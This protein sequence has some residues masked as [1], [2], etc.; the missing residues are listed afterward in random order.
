M[1]ALGRRM[2]CSSPSRHPSPATHRTTRAV[3]RTGR[4]LCWSLA[5]GMTTAA[6][7]LLLE[8]QAPWWGVVWPLPWYLTSLSIPAWAIL[9]ARQKT[10]QHPPDENHLPNS[11]DQAA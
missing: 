2:P 1:N 7:D 5:A 4:L 3:Q 11:W 6:A 8:P 9:R 10:T